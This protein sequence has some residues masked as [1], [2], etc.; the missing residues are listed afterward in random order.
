MFNFCRALFS[1]FLFLLIFPAV[2]AGEN[3]GLRVTDYYINHTSNDPFYSNHKLDPTVTLHVREVILAGRERTVAKDGKVLVLV[4][5]GTFPGAVA[6]DVDYKNASLMRHFAR[7]GWDTFALDLQ[8]YGSSTRPPIMDNP[9]AFPDDPAPMRGDVTIADVARVTDFVR[10]LRGVDKVH[11]L[12]WSGG[13]MIEVPRY[14]VQHP[15]KLE[16]IVLLGTNYLGWNRTEEKTKARI[17]KFNRAKIRLGYPMAVK[18]WESLGT[19]EEFIIPGVFDAY[20]KAHLAS[21]P[22]S[23]ELGGAIRAPYGRSVEI[24]IKEPHFEAEKI[25]VPTL[26]IR[27]DADTIATKE[28]NDALMAALGSEVKQL[29]EIPNAGHFLHFEITNQQFYQAVQDFLEAK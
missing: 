25:T 8:G 27:G 3:N 16:R 1:I 26:V 5:G 6:F 15:D 17:D 2:I 7:L 23:G 22:K 24:A 18:R 12:G 13:A 9:E 4:H 29:V 19:K 28:D 10:N 20:S 21:D 11:M 14:A